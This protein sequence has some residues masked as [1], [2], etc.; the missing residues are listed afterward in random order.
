MTTTTLIRRHISSL[1]DGQLFATR[2]VLVYGSRSA[3]DKTLSRMVIDG[4]IQRVARGV[5]VRINWRVGNVV[6]PIDIAQTK[7]RAFG[8]MIVRHALEFQLPAS[9]TSKQWPRYKPTQF[10][11]DTPGYS[12]SFRTIFGRIHFRN[13]AQRK[14]KLGD[15]EVGLIARSLWHLGNGAFSD[16]LVMKVIA[17][18]EGTE[19]QQLVEWSGLVPTWLNEI[20]HDV[21]EWKPRLL[22]PDLSTLF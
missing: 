10:I 20:F 22:L 4:F 1:P 12:S 19:R 2:D 21:I 18:L 3:V 13:A 14:I 7:A 6:R 8:R 11:Y 16:E 9:P 15:T 5:F 17:P